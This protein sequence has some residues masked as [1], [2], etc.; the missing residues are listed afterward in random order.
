MP[1]LEVTTSLPR[2]PCHVATLCSYLPATH[3]PN[4]KHHQHRGFGAHLQQAMAPLQSSLH[5]PYD[6]SLCIEHSITTGR[7]HTS[8]RQLLM[9]MRLQQLM[10]SVFV[11]VVTPAEP[12]T[13]WLRHARTECMNCTVL[14]VLAGAN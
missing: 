7:M 10:V 11:S 12:A 4:F 9:G 8:L 14:L 2:P 13:Q 6:H 5:A 3:Q 1:A